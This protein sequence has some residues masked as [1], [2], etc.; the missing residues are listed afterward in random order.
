MKDGTNISNAA[1]RTFDALVSG[2]YDN[3]VLFSCY[4]D[5]APT[6]AIA[7]VNREG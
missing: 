2:D 7:S 3:Y 4:V 6:S 1:R 5:G